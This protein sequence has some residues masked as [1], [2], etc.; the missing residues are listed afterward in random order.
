L[1]LPSTAEVN[2]FAQQ[3]HQ[4]ASNVL[5]AH[6]NPFSD[7]GQAQAQA[8]AQGQAQGQGWDVFGATGG[9]GQSGSAV[10]GNAQGGA[11]DPFI[12]SMPSDQEQHHQQQLGGAVAPVDDDWG[13]SD[14]TD[15]DIWGELP[16]KKEEE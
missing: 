16:S 12:T 7:Q 11:W 9:V 15:A 6:G 14:L 10:V 4:F 8:Q 13:L 2:P 3:Q 5:Q 1:A